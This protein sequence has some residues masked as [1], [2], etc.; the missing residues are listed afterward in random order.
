M[1]TRS[2]QDRNDERLTR[3]AGVVASLQ[4]QL[5]YAAIVRAANGHASF[6]V[7]C[8]SQPLRPVTKPVADSTGEREID[9]VSQSSIDCHPDNG[10]RDL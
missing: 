10:G 4:P 2:P 5:S 3:V 7:D 9:G 8:F 1:S 6:Q